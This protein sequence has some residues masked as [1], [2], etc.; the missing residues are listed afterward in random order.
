MAVPG[1]SCRGIERDALLVRIAVQD[2]LTQL[3]E[4]LRYQRVEDQ[5]RTRFL[6]ECNGNE[7]KSAACGDR[8]RRVTR[9]PAVV[10]YRYEDK[11]KKVYWF[12]N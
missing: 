4:A 7:S 11:D 2:E 8:T 10:N 12:E 5:R 6:V 9:W 1:S 3:E